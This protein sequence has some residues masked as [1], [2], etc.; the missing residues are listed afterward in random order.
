MGQN[1][2][3]TKTSFFQEKTSMSQLKPLINT[4]IAAGLL[5]QIQGAAQAHG[6]NPHG[7]HGAA[8]QHGSMMQAE[9]RTWGIV[10]DPKK[11]DRT[12]RI[13]MTDDMKFTPN[14]I[15]IK[16]NET[17]RFEI[18]NAGKVMHE[19]VIGTKQELDQHAAMMKKYPNMEHDEA[20]MAHVGPAK[21]GSIVWRFNKEGDFDFACLIAGHYDA[22]MVGKI[23]VRP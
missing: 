10:G 16:K 22:G 13:K 6:N 1:I 9:Q 20:Y 5:F 19:M 4:A 11:V 23:Q 15:S 21:S 3:S 2:I 17:I 8:A 12:I 14:V 18:Q 7:G